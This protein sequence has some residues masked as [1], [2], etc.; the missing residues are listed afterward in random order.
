ML[1]QIKSELR[2]KNSKYEKLLAKKKQLQLTTDQLTQN[3]DN[4]TETSQKLKQQ[5]EQLLLE[6]HSFKLKIEEL[7]SSVQTRITENER[8]VKNFYSLNKE[9]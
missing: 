3:L 8:L 7:D 1:E 4:Q 5:V 9:H 6:N 2:T